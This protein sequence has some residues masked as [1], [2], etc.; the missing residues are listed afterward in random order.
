[1]KLPHAIVVAAALV[2]AGLIL[3]GGIYEM[4]SLGNTVAKVR[5]NRL[6]GD[7]ALCRPRDGCLPYRAEDTWWD[8]YP[9]VTD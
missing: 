6:T 7:L 1:M 2:F 8:D 4:D 3:H 9:T 5:L